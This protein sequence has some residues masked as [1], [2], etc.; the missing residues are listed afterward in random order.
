[1]NNKINVLIDSSKNPL[2]IGGLITIRIEIEIIIFNSEYNFVNLY[3]KGQDSMQKKSIIEDCFKYSFLN[4]SIFEYEEKVKINWPRKRDFELD[5]FSYHSTSRINKL[6][7]KYKK[8]PKLEWNKKII[9][10]LLSKT[11]KINLS[12][13]IITHL[14]NQ[15]NGTLEDSN[16]DK[17]QWDTFFKNCSIKYQN[18]NFILIGN[19]IP[20]QLLQNKNV[21]NSNDINLNLFEEIAIS[22][23]SKGFLGLASGMSAGAIFSL[24]PYAILKHPK[25]HIKE[26][27]QEMGNKDNLPFAIKNQKIIRTTQTQSSIENALNI[28]LEQ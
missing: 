12:N 18:L 28:L 14:K 3:L 10:N 8:F 26:M 2:T 23:L 17:F 6:S 22:S 1:M 13:T 11:N 9:E 15:K 25:H 21:Y 20:K 19:D 16:V 24:K 7:I 4:F 5:D 27:N